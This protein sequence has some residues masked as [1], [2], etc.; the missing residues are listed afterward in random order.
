MWGEKLN[1]ISDLEVEKGNC[2]VNQDIIRACNQDIRQTIKTLS[3][4]ALATLRQKGKIWILF[5]KF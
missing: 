3:E 5:K 1:V 2:G 4:V